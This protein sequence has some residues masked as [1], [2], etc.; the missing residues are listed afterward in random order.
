MPHWVLRALGMSVL[1]AAAT[2]ALAK[3]AVFQ[4]GETTLAR[5]TAIALLVGA[6]AL[7]SA[8]D[9]WTRRPD[10]GRTWF[11][12]GLVTGPA[13]G[14]LSV[15]GKAVL[16]DRTGTSELGA[17]LTSGAAFTA[18]LVL[19]PAG[20]GLVVGSRLPRPGSDLDGEPGDEDVAD[21]PSGRRS[22]TGRNASAPATEGPVRG[23][24]SRRRGSRSAP[25]TDTPAATGSA[26]PTPAGR[27]ER[28]ETVLLTK[29][30]PDRRPRPTPRLRAR[31]ADRDAAEEGDDTG[32]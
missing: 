13:A 2:V 6:A 8:L 11:I 21:E 23:N 25:A 15:I 16:V 12:A 5:S 31:R 29:P 26:A 30:R 19:V 24:R 1:H 7:W 10:G 18:L 14:V 20:L 32:H 22:A 28:N 27:D 9:G 17:A 3:I 4:P